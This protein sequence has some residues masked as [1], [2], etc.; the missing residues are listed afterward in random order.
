MDDREITRVNREAWNEATAY[1]QKA[2]RDRLTAGFADPEFTTF[3]RDCD[4]ALLEMLRRAVDLTGKT[5]AQIPCN[6]GRELLSLMRL[7]AAK[8]VGYDISDAAIDEA[9]RLADIAGLDAEFQRVDILELDAARDGTLDF[10]FISEGS[11]QWFP[12]LSDYF[13]VIARL[14]KPGGT[15]LIHEIHPFAYFFELGFDPARDTDFRKLTSYFDKEPHTYADGLDYVGGTSY[16]AKPCC[17]FMHKMSDIIAAL[18]GCG[19]ELREFEEYSTEVTNTPA[20]MALKSF[21]L[22]YVMICVKNQP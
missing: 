8:A 16:E 7:G 14:L 21:P 3:D 4:V 2:R 19:L 15:V 1:H 13:A 12:E 22:S 18:R 10:V 17:W 6:N 5:I 11:L 20:A 9:R